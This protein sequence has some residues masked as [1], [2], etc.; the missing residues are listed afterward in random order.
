MAVLSV[1]ILW[2]FFGLTHVGLMLSAVLTSVV[3]A[4]EAGHMFAFR[5]MGHKTARMIILPFLGG[6]A[7]GGRPY[8]THFEVGFSALM[9]AG[10]SVSR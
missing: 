9:G 6:I 10:M 5:A 8:N 4:H 2:P 7:L 3:I 1:L